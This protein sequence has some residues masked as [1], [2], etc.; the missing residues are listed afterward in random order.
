MEFIKFI[1]END[2][3]N[4]IS[5]L[6]FSIRIT[7][8]NYCHLDAIYEI[9][10][11]YIGGG[12]TSGGVTYNLKKN[13]YSYKINISHEQ[14]AKYH[15][16]E[17]SARFFEHYFKKFYNIVIYVI[18]MKDDIN[19]DFFLNIK[20]KH[21]LL[22]LVCIYYGYN[23]FESDKDLQ[24]Y[25][26]KAN[27]LLIEGKI[28]K[29]FEIDFETKEGVEKLKQNFENDSNFFVQQKYSYTNGQ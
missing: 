22:Y 15:F 19:E 4:Y 29:L 10:G 11:I 17:K 25:R 21:N 2:G 12:Q 5:V 27:S 8:N 18:E 24:L 7:G 1:N 16:Y 20:K 9:T 13:N 3:K 28:N 6:F 23:K 14:Y 26:I